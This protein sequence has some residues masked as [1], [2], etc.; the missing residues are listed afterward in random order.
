MLGNKPNYC[1]PCRQARSLALTLVACPSQAWPT[2]R[3]LHLRAWREI[4]EDVDMTGAVW[5]DGKGQTVTDLRR[6]VVVAKDGQKV[7]DHVDG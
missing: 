6:L 5:V 1:Q 7:G 2:G 4:A 3:R